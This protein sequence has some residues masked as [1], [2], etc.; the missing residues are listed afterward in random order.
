MSSLLQLGKSLCPR[1]QRALLSSLC[2]RCKG[3]QDPSPA[4][5]TH[6]WLKHFGNTMQVPNPLQTTLETKWVVWTVGHNLTHCL[7]IPS[8][9]IS[10]VPTKQ[11]PYKVA[12]FLLIA[13]KLSKH[14]GALS[15]QVARV[16]KVWHWQIAMVFGFPKS[17]YQAASFATHV[18]YPTSVSY[19]SDIRMVKPSGGGPFTTC[20]PALV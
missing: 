18:V 10:W 11:S 4:L 3:L 5:P 19:S 17:F 8:L 16:P 15:A 6:P 7:P 12:T 1:F 14:L 2:L 13:Q 9:N 20:F